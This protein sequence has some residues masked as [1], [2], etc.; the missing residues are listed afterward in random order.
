[1]M[2]T[3]AM[4]ADVGS[5][6]ELVLRARTDRDALGQLYDRHY[7]GVLR[8]C[9]HRLFERGAAEDVTSTVFLEVARQVRS[10]TGKT[11][12]D[13]ANWL[14]A[15]ATNQTNAHIRT[16]LRHRELLGQAARKQQIRLCVNRDQQVELR[17]GWSRLY[18]AIAALRPREQ[19]IITLRS[20]EDLPYE[21]IAT[22]VGV[23]VATAR[24]VYHRA[25]KKLRASLGGTTEDA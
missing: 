8:Y 5:G 6:D 17:L 16:V 18:E 1:M 7:P 22:V 19:A 21:R 25:L 14:Y 12:Q 20:F 2:A 15:I 13:F 9:I 4:T 11:E 10:F 24:V 23:S 3:D